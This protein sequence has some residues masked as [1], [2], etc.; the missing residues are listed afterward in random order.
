MSFLGIHIVDCLILLA[1]FGVILYLGVVVGS[2][3]TQTLGDFFV[4][5]GRWGALVSFVFV[6]AS[7]IAGNEAV[8]V[9]GKSYTSGLSGV[10]YWWSFLFATPVYYLFCTYY[11]RARVYNLAEFLE[12]RYGTAVAG[13]YALVAGVICILFIA[14]VL[15][16]IGKILAGFTNFQLPACIWA[17][18][19]VVALYVFSG[20]MMSALLTDLVQGVMCL[21]IL[22]FIMF[23]FVWREAGGFEALSQ[24]PPETWDFTSEG[25]TLWTVLALN[26]SALAGGIALP[27]IYSWI[28]ISKDE[29][30]ATQCGWA[31]LWKR[32]ITLLFAVYGILFALCAE[33]LDDPEL[34]WG[35]VMR[36]VLPSGV[37]AVGLMIA[38]FFASALSS[39]DT[40]ATTSSAMFVDYGYRKLL[41][42]GRPASHYLALA[43]VCAV[44]SI[45]LAAA[46]THFFEDIKDYLKMGMSLLSFLGVPIYFGIA[47]RRANRTGMWVSLSLGICSYVAIRHVMTGEGRYFVTADDAFVASVFIPTSLSLAGMWIG[48]LLGRPE[49]PLMLKRFHVVMNTRIGE[50]RRL[51][52]AGIQLP[53][54][55]EAQLAD[56]GVEELNAGVLQQLYAEDASRKVFGAESTIEI[57]S[58]VDLTWYYRGFVTITLCCAG[59]IVSTWLL[60]RVLFVW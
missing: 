53:A 35:T 59:L 36:D 25:M 32:V 11:R 26:V 5:G 33:G 22:G 42:P 47:W 9:S 2:R 41:R 49:D 39:A 50:E 43:R 16:A 21:L 3:K 12:M 18:S 17:I 15:L 40:M 48:S 8:V 24:L 45:V 4:A 46:S 13:L 14:M 57:Y 23:P 7:A 19:I 44:V 29:R 31:H 38:S 56:G 60:T 55:V 34:A 10:W 28:A 6:F 1:Y 58:E 51:L 54:L 20:G 37:G 52:E 27:W 30:A